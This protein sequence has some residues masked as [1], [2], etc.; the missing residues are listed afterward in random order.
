MQN[1]ITKKASWGRVLII[2]KN[3]SGGTSD[4]P[5]VPNSHF[6]INFSD[7]FQALIQMS[8]DCTTQTAKLS[9]DGQNIYTNCCTLRIDYSKLPCLNVKFN[10]EKSFDYTRSDLPYGENDMMSKLT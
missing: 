4:H 10:N 1:W 3:V 7:Q 8:D 5:H 6:L 9:L 2:S